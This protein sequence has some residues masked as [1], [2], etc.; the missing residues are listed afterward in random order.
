MRYE[1]LVGDDV[2]VARELFTFLGLDLDPAVEAFCLEQQRERTPF[3]NPARDL[4]VGVSES[5]WSTTFTPEQRL[6]SLELIGDQLVRYGYETEVSLE[7]LAEPASRPK[8]GLACLDGHKLRGGQVCAS[9]IF[10][11]GSPRS[12][13]TMLGW[14]LAH[15]SL[16][17]TSGE[18]NVIQGIFKE[19][20]V[21]AVLE[22]ARVHGKGA[23]L[24]HQQVD[25]AELLR[26]LG[27]GVNALYTS[28]SGDKRWLDHTPANTLAIDLLGEL[29]PR[30]VF[31]HMLRDGRQVVG[32]DGQLPLGDA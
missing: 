26:N 31:L 20:A 3:S 10:V 24:T 30:A 17:W 1:H 18:A 19:R 11:V 6:R 5:P 27:L 23:W 9:P 29:F 7:A 13:T 8:P 4:S 22:H 12:G 21:E 2:A 25:R 14:S 16:L 28:R 32:L 15:H